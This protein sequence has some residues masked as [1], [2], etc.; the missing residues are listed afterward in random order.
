[1]LRGKGPYDSLQAMIYI[2]DRSMTFGALRMT[3]CE[4]VSVGGH[5]MSMTHLTLTALGLML[6]IDKQSDNDV[7]VTGSRSLNK[8]VDRLLF[9]KVKQTVS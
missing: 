8:N 9:D 7:V 5:D 2:S 6:K 1:M 3:R 4:A